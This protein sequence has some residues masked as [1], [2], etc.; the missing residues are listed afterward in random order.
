MP[1]AS[2]N[3]CQN[4]QPHLHRLITS[5]LT[6]AGAVSAGITPALPACDSQNAMFSQWLA[7]GHHAGMAYMANHGSLRTDPRTLLPGTQ[8]LISVAFPY[9][10]HRFRHQ[11]LPQIATYAY[12]NDYHDALRKL[13]QTAVEQI[14]TH[15]GGEWRICI[16][17]APVYERYWA[18]ITHTA[19]RCD[20]GLVNVPGWGTRVFLAEI[21]TTVALSP[22][23]PLFTTPFPDPSFSHTTP[24]QCIHCGKCTTA[25][26][27]GA[28]QPDGTLCAGRCLSYLTIEHRGPWTGEG[29]QA[30]QTPQGRNTLYGCDICQNVCP[31]NRLTLPDNYKLPIDERPE[32]I[33]LE[34]AECIALHPERFSRIF[35]KSPIKRTKAE[36]L[37]RNAQNLSHP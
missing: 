18:C 10:P 1:A 12:G 21:L 33:N 27:A 23:K 11:S 4:I 29:L 31:L 3:D 13:L 5:V 17:S 9:L 20:S 32:I 28:L 7:Q 22:A 2:H 35:S 24:I 6:Q 37:S 30:M 19:T 14:K 25:C 8:S 16:D 34:A 26:P 15:T 36:G